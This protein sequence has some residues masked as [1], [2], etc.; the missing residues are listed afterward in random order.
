MRAILT[1]IG[2]LALTL[3]VAVAAAPWRPDPAG[4][5]PPPAIAEAPPATKAVAAPSRIVRPE[6][7]APPEVETRELVR[8]EPRAPL[9]ELSLAK[10]KR[11]MKAGDDGGKLLFQPVAVGSA[12]FQSMG[13]DVTIA[14]VESVDPGQTC[15]S[16]GI[17]WPCGGRAIG[18][19]RRW[20]RGRALSC[21]LPEEALRGE[22]VAACRLGRQDIGAWVVSMGWATA[23]PGGPYAE[24]EAA[25]RQH[26][27][28]IFGPAPAETLLPPPD[29]LPDAPTVDL[30][31]F[32]PLDEGDAI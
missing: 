25:A 2:L 3:L 22:V 32:A 10:P 4:P 24:A 17:E 20:L 26:A 28:G 6:S 13:F 21:D 5:P 16:Q 15:V 27:M 19:V 18:E 14:G 7:V 31:E 9:S 11:R 30:G 1:A 8:E 23:A 12:R 29:E